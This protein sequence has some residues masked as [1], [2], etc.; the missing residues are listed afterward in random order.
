NQDITPQQEQWAALA[1]AQ[2]RLARADTQAR[3]S[4]LIDQ[5]LIGIAELD[6]EGR[7]TRVNDRFAEMLGYTREELQGQT[8][9][10]ITD[11]RD[12]ADSE[13]HLRVTQRGE[14]FILENRYRCK[15][16]EFLWGKVMA[17]PVVDPQTQTPGVLALIV[18][19]DAAK[20]AEQ[21]L[22]LALEASQIGMYDWDMVNGHIL[23]NPEHERHWGYRP[24][25]FDGSYL[26]F[27]RRVHPDDLAEVNATIESAKTARQPYRHAFRVVWPDASVHWINVRGEFEYDTAG[28]ALHMRGTVLDITDSV[29]RE[30]ELREQKDRLDE[31]QRIARIGHW[32]HTLDGHITW[33]P[34]VYRQLGVEPGIFKPTK[35]ALVALI[36]PE[37]RASLW[38]WLKQLRGG[39]GPEPLT[40]RRYRP[41]GRLCYLR[42]QGELQHDSQGQPLRKVGTLQDVTEIQQAMEQLRQSRQHLTLA[43]EAGGLGACHWDLASHRIQGINLFRRFFGLPEAPAYDYGALME[44]VHPDDRARVD[45]ALQRAMAAGVEFAEE[46]RILHPDGTLIWVT[47][48]AQIRVSADGKSRS[49]DGILVDITQ[50]KLAEAHLRQSESR[51]LLATES[52]QIGTWYWDTVNDTIYLS[53]RCEQHLVLPPGTAFSYPHFL[54]I[55]HPDDRDATDQSVQAALREHHGYAHEYRVAQADGGYR[56]IQAAGKGVYDEAG[57]LVGLMGVTQDM[58]ERRAMEDQILALNADLEQKVEQRTQQLAA[59][60]A[61]KSQFL[62]SMSHE[63]RT[64]MNAVLGLAQL[65]EDEPLTEDQLQMVQR[66]NSAGRSLMGILNDILDFSK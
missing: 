5:S 59:A 61:A 35:E 40:L 27:T 37:D 25:E 8:V 18:D 65:L 44:R 56:W 26:G 16:G 58:T 46:Y 17:M 10:D 48:R 3:L 55:L 64:P 32:E 45:G 57:T 49:L 62:A 12:W 11:P 43:M 63:I 14:S 50:R 51:L 19:I 54:S 42:L 29:L 52:G 22:R 13:A 28:H 38:D 33:S 39:L 34:E 36:H 7:M 60:N 31:A 21:R 24:G 1:E 20:Q 66:I 30:A 41:D 4:A 2:A 6:A 53:A 9:Q 47:N 15:S 23:W